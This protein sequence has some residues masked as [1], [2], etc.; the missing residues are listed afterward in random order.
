MEKFDFTK[1]RTYSGREQLPIG[2]YVCQIVGAKE[3]VFD[4]GKRLNIAFDV[5]EGEY[6]DIFKRDYDGNTNENKKW[7]GVFKLGIPKDDGSEQDAWAKKRFGN[8]VWALEESNPGYYWDWDEKKLK[9]K[10]IGFIF[11]NEEW[12][13]DGRSGWSTKAGGVDSIDNIRAGKYRMLPDKPLKNKPAPAVY[14]VADNADDLP[15]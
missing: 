2:G 1:Q 9:G 3:E 8:F 12:A 13:V 5:C 11:R 10:K 6:K 4:W 15:F 14:D 7:R